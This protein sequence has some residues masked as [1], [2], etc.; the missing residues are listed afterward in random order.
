MS[1]FLTRTLLLASL[2]TAPYF[3]FAAEEKVTFSVEGMNVVGT[4]N[5]PDG[6]KKPPV[7]LLL[8]S[9]GGSRDEHIIPAVNEGIYVRA[10]RLWAEQ[11]IASLRIDYRFDGESDGAKTDGT[12]DTGVEDGLAA[13]DFLARSGRVDASRM[14]LVGW[15]MGGAIGA[16]V[17]GRTPHK[18]DAVA[19]WNPATNM[20]AAFPL[21]WGSEKIKEALHSGDTPVVLA[22]PGGGEIKLKSAFFIGLMTLDA[23]AEITHYKGP[24]LV[25]VG[26]NDDIVFPQPT[27]GKS[28]I[29]HHPG[30]H[31]L[32]VRPMDHA[33]N[34][35]E[36]EKQIDELISTTAT[37][38]K[39]HIH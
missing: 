10:A 19:L 3:A 25:A 35:T 23:A 12:L 1:T 33:F 32:L 14:A 9:F 28:F 7:I 8:H 38:V 18:L 21:L 15:S 34:M 29:S 22:I 20:G 11:G 30:K 5:L 39:K 2:I 6:V 37:F 31:E 24:L 27:L 17:A 26:T 13:L 16:A 4:L 36:D